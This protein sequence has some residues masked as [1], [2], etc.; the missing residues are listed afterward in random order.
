MTAAP[1]AVDREPAPIEEH[2]AIGDGRSIAL[3]DGRGGIVWL[4]WPRFDSDP[5]FAALLDP[6]RGGVFR[7]APEGLSSHPHA[8]YIERTNVVRTVFHT[9]GGELELLDLM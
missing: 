1:L 2:L 3:G 5:V 7:I 8:R 4:A 6:E 9:P